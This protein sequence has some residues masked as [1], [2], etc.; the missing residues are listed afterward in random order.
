MQDAPPAEAQGGPVGHFGERLDRLGTDEE[1]ERPR[2]RAACEGR[3]P[4]PSPLPSRPRLAE[5]RRRGRLG[6][7]G[8]MRFDE[9]APRHRARPEP[10]AQAI[11]EVGE[12]AG[13]LGLVRPLELDL[14]GRERLGRKAREAHEV[15][16]EA[17]VDRVLMRAREPLGEEPR[18]RARFVQRPGG[19]DPDAAHVAVDAIEAELD[20]PRALGLTLEQHHE[21]VG[22][23]A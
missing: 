10:R 12:R 2:R 13:A 21:I 7:F 20:P 23:L 9:R 11:D 8:Q 15:D 1:P 6:L 19:A 18:D 5:R 3:N 16:A 4:F 14:R 17:G 22:E